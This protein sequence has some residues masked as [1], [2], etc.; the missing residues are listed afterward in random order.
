MEIEHSEL[1]D[2]A[3]SEISEHPRD[4]ID[5][6]REEPEYVDHQWHHQNY[7]PLNWIEMSRLL[8]EVHFGPNRSFMK[9]FHCARTVPRRRTS[10]ESF[11][12]NEHFSSSS[13]SEDADD[14]S[15]LQLCNRSRNSYGNEKRMTWSSGPVR[16]SELFITRSSV[17]VLN[18]PVG[19]SM[20]RLK[21]EL[22]RNYLKN[23][24][25]K[26][27]NL[28]NDYYDGLLSCG[29][30]KSIIISSIDCFA[31]SDVTIS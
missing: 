10:D 16:A 14:R 12:S 2:S 21:R 11:G 23:D 15:D 19:N 26:V 7:N 17:T 22:N 18:E 9:R 29:D 20:R 28:E 31:S 13:D 8:K 3:V 24:R 6:S 5:V 27:G 1:P 25:E 4:T 30:L